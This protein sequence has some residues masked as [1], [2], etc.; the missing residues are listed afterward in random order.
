[1]NHTNLLPTFFLQLDSITLP[2]PALGLIKQDPSLVDHPV[3]LQIIMVEITIIMVM[4]EGKQ[5]LE[6]QVMVQD[7]TIK[8]PAAV[9]RVRIAPA[10]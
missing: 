3:L 8:G 5:T 1:M 7:R 2:K 6:T 10:C 4:E 9:V